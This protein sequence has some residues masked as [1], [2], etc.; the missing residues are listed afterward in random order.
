MIAC[1]QAEFNELSRFAEKAG[2]NADDME[3]ARL[4]VAQSWLG[5]PNFRECDASG[6]K[7]SAA[8]AASSHGRCTHF[9]DAS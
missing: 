1:R 3:K 6:S 2:E 9:L 7:K 4:V 5:G 8:A